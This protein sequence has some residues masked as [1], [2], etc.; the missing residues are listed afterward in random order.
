MTKA[1]RYEYSNKKSFVNDFAPKPPPRAFP[2]LQTSL[3]TETAKSRVCASAHRWRGELVRWAGSP[4]ITQLTNPLG[5][6][7]SILRP[8]SPQ[9]WQGRFVARKLDLWGGGEVGR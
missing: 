8:P 6:R 5:G 2:L 3:S 7:S 1:Q 4:T 9:F